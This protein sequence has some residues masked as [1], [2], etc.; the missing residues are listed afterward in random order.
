MEH[1]LEVLLTQDDV[2]K[3]W[4]VCP[5][6]VYRR[7][8]AGDIPYVQ[9]SPRSIRYR[10]EDVLRYIEEHQRQEANPSSLVDEVK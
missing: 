3:I 5:K 4:K 2:A 7:R 1:T 8:L 10:I 9:I 6:T